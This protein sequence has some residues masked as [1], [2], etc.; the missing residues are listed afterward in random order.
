MALGE[1]W[2]ASDGLGHSGWRPRYW[3]EG[4]AA[5]R[6]PNACDGVQSVWA[7]RPDLLRLRARDHHLGLSHRAPAI[8]LPDRHSRN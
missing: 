5:R 1:R 8:S 2:Y 3:T 7:K 4:Y 6:I